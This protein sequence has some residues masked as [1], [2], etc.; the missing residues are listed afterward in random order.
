MVWVGDSV[1]TMLVA[2]PGRGGGRNDRREMSPR[3]PART[4]ALMFAALAA[5]GWFFWQTHQP[6]PAVDV[7]LLS[8]AFDGGAP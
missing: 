5:F 6:R 4:I 2:R 7:V 8:P 3:F 1:M